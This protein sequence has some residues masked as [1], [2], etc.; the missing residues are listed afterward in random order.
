MRACEAGRYLSLCPKYLEKLC[1]Q[2]REII[3]SKN[4][5]FNCLRPYQVKT[6]C[7]PKRYRTCRKQHHTTLHSP[8]SNSEAVTAVIPH[9]STT[10]LA[11]SHASTREEIHILPVVDGSRANLQ[12]QSQVANQRVINR[13]PVLLATAIVT[14]ISERGN[15]SQMRALVDQESE[16]SFVSESIAQLLRL[17]RRA[18]TIPIRGIGAQRNDVSNGIVSLIIA[19]RINSNACFELTALVLSKLTAYLP[20]AQLEY[21]QWSHSQFP[22]SRF[23]VHYTWKN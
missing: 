5:C 2:R 7:N 17:P 11:T 8:T 3:S 1:D 18:A 14:V 19:S 13:A 12:S 16:V 23:D 10:Q 21:T 22:L 6:C 9:T 4:L 20:P 15:S